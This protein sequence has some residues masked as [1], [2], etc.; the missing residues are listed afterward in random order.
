M[1]EYKERSHEEEAIKGAE[2]RGQSFGRGCLGKSKKQQLG[3]SKSY[4]IESGYSELQPEDQKQVPKG[5]QG[6]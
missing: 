6:K 1:K 2:Q 4:E 3:V 5:A